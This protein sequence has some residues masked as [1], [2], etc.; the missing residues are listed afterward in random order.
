MNGPRNNFFL[1]DTDSRFRLTL[2]KQ[3]H[4]SM[5]ASSPSYSLSFVDWSN[6]DFTLVPVVHV[7]QHRIQRK[8]LMSSIP[9][10]TL[11]QR[12]QQSWKNL[13]DLGQKSWY[14]CGILNPLLQLGYFALLARNRIRSLQ[15]AHAPDFKLPWQQTVAFEEGWKTSLPF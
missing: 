14:S 3:L 13:A 12:I 9:K 10:T 4:P 11:P 5:S 2:R 15:T 8:N 7:I 1:S 6:I